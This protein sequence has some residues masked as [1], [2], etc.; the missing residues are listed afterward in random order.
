MIKSLQ[1]TG[2]IKVIPLS[3]LGNRLRVMATAIKLARKSNKRLY[4]YWQPNKYLNADFVDLFELPENIQISRLPLQYKIWLRT[5]SLSP[6]FKKL[7]R[8][9]L[10]LFNFDFIFLDS[11]ASQ[12][13]HNKLDLEKKVIESKDVFICGCQELNYFDP[14]DYNL[15]IPR[16]E[17]L[18]KVREISNRFS[19]NTHGIHIRSTDNHH[20]KEKSPFLLFV[21]V[22]EDQLKKEPG[23]NFFLATDN[24]DYQ[25]RLVEIFG[26]E[27][28]L[29]NHKD[30]R[31]DVTEGIK[32]AVIDLY[33]L[34]KT[35]KI[36]G[37]YFSSF[38][39][40]GGRIGNVPV[41]I[42]KE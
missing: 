16:K 33:C 21:K 23:S 15:F 24:E 7:A 29:F 18:Q 4:I 13:W 6:L 35:A 31:R 8:G 32:D 26:R 34:S 40:I 2:S 19:P 1:E 10:R 22:I 3:G 42:V 17:L 20:S 11:M 37:S 28:I 36:Y 27:K 14:E 25:N 30:F 9:Y 41:E 12:V 38:S 5:S 39:Y